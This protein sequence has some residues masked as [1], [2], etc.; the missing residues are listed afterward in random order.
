MKKVVPSR[1]VMTRL[2]IYEVIHI[3]KDHFI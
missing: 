1:D 3:L 2:D